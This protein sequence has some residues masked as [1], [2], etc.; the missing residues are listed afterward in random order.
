MTGAAV[1]IRPLGRR[2]PDT[3][4]APEASCWDCSPEAA[5]TLTFLYIGRFVPKVYLQ[6]GIFGGMEGIAHA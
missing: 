4:E 1:A 6:S 5:L 3:A 2:W